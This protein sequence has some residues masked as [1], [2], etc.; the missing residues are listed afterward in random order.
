MQQFI[1]HCCGPSPGLI[2]S[3]ETGWAAASAMPAQWC[4]CATCV[5]ALLWQ[6]IGWV[7]SMSRACASSGENRLA[8]IATI[9]DMETKRRILTRDYTAEF[10]QKAMMFLVERY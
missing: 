10:S 8:A 5:F 9:A 7:I 6:A 1:G 2:V 4:L 3:L